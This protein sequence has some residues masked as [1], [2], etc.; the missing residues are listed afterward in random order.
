MSL[1][2]YRDT[3]VKRE[4]PISVAVK[5]VETMKT[6]HF[7]LP[8]KTHIKELAHQLAELLKL[9]PLRTNFKF[10]NSLGL[11]TFNP[12]STLYQN[13]V[14]SG[15]TLIAKMI[16]TGYSEA[17]KFSP[18][19]S[20]TK[21]KFFESSSPEK[22]V[23]ETQYPDYKIKSD[24]VMLGLKLFGA[25]QNSKCVAYERKVNY[26]IGMGIF[27]LTKLL[28]QTKCIACKRNV[29]VTGLYLTDCFWKVEGNYID[30][31]GFLNTKYM[32]YFNKTD[33]TDNE[34]LY[35]KLKETKFID[36]KIT[37]KPF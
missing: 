27:S 33:G 22:Y 30:L 17:K 24:P 16:D 25:C 10:S 29:K 21:E 23:E 14:K 8:K 32:K 19:K 26:P 37:V 11:E 3:L 36:P 9:D 35:E 7:E 1:Q 15:D 4:R 28:D 31:N 34:L 12:S 2:N 13:H 18:L 5:V 6:Y 20:V